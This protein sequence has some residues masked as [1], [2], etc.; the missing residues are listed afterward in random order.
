MKP[1]RFW[2]IPLELIMSETVPEQENQ[3]RSILPLRFDSEIE[4]D[5]CGYAFRP[6][7]GFEM[8]INGSVYLYS[9]DGSFEI[10]LIGGRLEEN[11]SIAELN[12]ELTAEFMENVD[13]Y[14]LIESGTDIIQGITG[15]LNEI[16][17]VN[18]EEEGLGR[19]LI[20]SPFINQY[21]YMLI[22]ASS[23]DWEK[24]GL[25]VFDAVKSQVHFHPQFKPEVIE[26]KT[27]KH[28]DLTQETYENITLA[29][30]VVLT[31]EKGDLSLLLAARSELPNEQVWISEITTPDG[32]TLYKYDPKD[33]DFTSSVSDH[34][35]EDY[36]GEVVFFLPRSSNLALPAGEY[37]FSFG[38][39]RERP[40]QEVQVIIRAGRAL[41]L[42]K[43]DLNFW[44]AVEDGPFNEAENVDN[45]IEDIRKALKQR[46]EPF[47]L[48]PGKIDYYHPAPDELESFHNL[49]IDTDIADCSYL[50]SEIVNNGRALNIALVDSFYSETA[51]NIYEINALS[52]GSPGMI[53]ASAS[54]HSCIFINWSAVHDDIF[55]MA[56]TIIQQLIIFSGIDLKDVQQEGTQ[57][58][59]LNREIAW[60]LRRHP[61]FYDAS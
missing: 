10:N 23:R 41:D 60:R 50:I 34:P 8:E 47:S 27:E 39:H 19:A 15:F 42:Q 33:A 57:V 11:I 36:Q 37:R 5:A 20:C 18:V 22:I 16:R 7:S 49:N 46:L 32:S 54:P 58:L 59:T 48:T 30:E 1:S 26:R 51:E 3:S 35:L 14:D 56:E 43:V 13:N 61:L 31:I 21:F 55:K 44:I 40:L 9:E 28:P 52:A 17:F 29:D 38:T 2:S 6:I 25:D 45:F 53:L 4:M 12:N 24:F